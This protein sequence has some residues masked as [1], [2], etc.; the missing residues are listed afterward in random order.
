[1]YVHA[2][3]P[4]VSDKHITKK[5]G[6]YINASEISV[7]ITHGHNMHILGEVNWSAPD[8]PLYLPPLPAGILWAEDLHSS[9][10][11]L[12]KH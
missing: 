8:H 9:P 2:P 4:P 5:D 12:E 1:M 11:S 6:S 7:S 10:D 3:S